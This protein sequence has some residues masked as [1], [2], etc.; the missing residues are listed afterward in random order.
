MSARIALIDS[1][2]N[3]GHSH[4]RGAAA[5]VAGPIVGEDGTWREGEEQ[6]DTLGHGTAAAAAIL[7]LA[8]GSELYSIQI[9]DG[10]PAC[11]FELVLAALEHAIERRPRPDLVNLSLGTPRA[12]WNEQLA[13][14]VSAAAARGV[15]LVAPAAFDGLPCYP[16][17]L[18]GVSGVLM[19]ARL[20]RERPELREEPGHRFWYASPYPR[21]LPGLPRGAN[22]AGVSMATANLTGYLASRRARAR[23]SERD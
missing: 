1:G 15:E 10:R 18:P 17:C 5:I 8:P 11:P 22:L 12:D 23:D 13:E 16:G 14:L 20:P 19:D 6:V 7:H 2:V 4:L 9:F 21:D 3:R